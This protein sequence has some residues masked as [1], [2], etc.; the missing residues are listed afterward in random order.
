MDNSNNLNNMAPA[1]IYPGIGYD[2]ELIL[3]LKSHLPHKRVIAFDTLPECPHYKP[4]QNGWVHTATQEA[5]FAK[6][7]HE[8][9]EYTIISDREL[10]FPKVNMSYALTATM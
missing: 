10:Y 4:G 5:F 2:E 3:T 6:L 9:G 8:Y 7:K 1:L